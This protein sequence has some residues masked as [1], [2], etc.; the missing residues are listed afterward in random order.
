MTSRHTVLLLVAILATAIL[1]LPEPAASLVTGLDDLSSDT[2]EPWWLDWPADMDR[3]GIH[4]TLEDVAARALA[5][6]PDARVDLVVDLD[7]APRP[8]DLERLEL[9]G[10]EIDYVSRYVDAVLGSLPTSAI[11]LVRALPDVVMLEAQGV[12]TPLLAS[13]V[14]TVGIDRVWESLGYDGTGVT[15]AVLDTGISGSHQSLDDLDDDPTT[16]DPKIV[17]FFD[18]YTNSTTTPY[19]AGEHGT[20]TAGIATGTGQPGGENIGAA[21]GAKLVGVRIGSEGGFP[22]HTA[23]RGIEWVIDNRVTFNISVMSCSWGIT[24]GGPNDHNGNSAISR[25]ADE[26]VAEGIN[27]VVSAGN[28][29]L[30]ATV[31]A[32]GDAFNVI[33][34]GSVD[35]THRI[36]SFSSEGP[37]TDGRTKPDVCAPGEDISGP[38]SSSDSGWFTGDGTS[39]SAPMVSGL[40]ALMMEANPDLTP[41]QVKQILHETSEHNTALALKYLFTPNNGYGW[42]V[43]HAGGAVRRARDLKSP[44]I[45]IPSSVESGEDLDLVAAGSYSRSEHTDRGENGQSRFGEDEVHIEATIPDDWER[46]SRVTYEMVGNMFATPIPEPVVQQD[47]KW[48]VAVTFRPVENVD[49]IET[50][51]PTIRFTT[52]APV[53]STAKTYALTARE[54]LNN[55]VGTMGII[56]VSVGGNVPPLIE[57][58][59]PG[60]GPDK[61]DSSYLIRWTDDD[62]DDNA[63]IT[64]YND[65]DTDPD[66][67]R[68]L[69]AS[70]IREDPEGDGD[71]YLWNTATLL[72]GQSF[73]IQAVIED[74]LNDPYSTYSSGTVTIDHTGNSPPFVDI[75]EPNGQNDEADTTYDIEYV[76]RD[77]DDVALVDLY[78]DEDSSGYDGISIARGL[79]EADG[80]SR[81]TWDTSSLPDGARLSVY[82]VAS[83]GNNP[84]A[85][86]YSKG[87]I[88]ISHRA[89]PQI[90]EHS[91]TGQGVALDETLRVTFD[92]DMDHSATEGALSMVP[93]VTG[94]FSWV[95]NTMRFDPNGGWSQRTSYNAMISTTARD[96]EGRQMDTDF[97]WTFVTGD[98]Q[99]PTGDPE[100]AIETPLEGET[101]SGFAWVEGS[102]E[103]LGSGG[104][105]EVR[106]D[107]DEWQT[108]SGNERWS[109][110][111]DTGAVADRDHTI[112]AR[113]RT[114]DGTTSPVD[115]VNVKVRNELNSPPTVTDVV[116]REVTAEQD[117]SIQVEASDP[118]GDDLVYSDDTDLFEVNAATGLIIF[119]PTEAQVGTWKV[120]VTVSDGTVQVE[121]SFIITVRPVDDAG[122]ILGVLPLTPF[123]VLLVLVVIVSIVGALAYR[124]KRRSGRPATSGVRGNRQ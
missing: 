77:P 35:D 30:S 70:G 18:A 21:P 67:G 63:R 4:D 52:T 99:P 95:G 16:D 6:D 108:A 111:W 39:A 109:W 91:P 80:N 84:Q 122:G 110:A 15:V 7:R 73:Y 36:S 96:S 23:L 45:D 124:S 55:M 22:E 34:V 14:P 13:A 85:R 46:P 89:G 50:G 27:V 59:S 19:D 112:S 58:V 41:A 87:P 105:V 43:I 69:I 20:W 31:T 40:V 113:G 88:T 3:D 1:P 72:E 104:V 114:A 68:V 17:T 44:S 118:D 123:E 25:A 33:T 37:T 60:G 101:L 29:A 62:P 9:L 79:Q 94:K 93:V 74:G 28:S 76:A 120:S 119:T 117:V 121:I 51:Y 83:D 78:W 86:A 81:Y 115:T 66:D 54:T 49:T 38:W 32:P 106:I 48:V 24:L 8:V 82:I 61:A 71:S 98:A 47:G 2:G 12:G 90:V 65:L 116:D 53:T 56:R 64:L 97:E 10:M 92:R 102:S 107:G 26:A 42:G 100:V 103:N 5:S 75:L 11:S 57:I